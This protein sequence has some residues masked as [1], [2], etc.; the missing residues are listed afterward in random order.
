MKSILL[1]GGTG[2]IGT[3]FIN[4]FKDKF[5]IYILKRKSNKKSNIKKHKNIFLIYYKNINEIEY[6]I[7]RKKFDYLIN[8]A[9]HYTN[10]NDTNNLIKIVESNILFSTVVLNAINKNYLKKIISIGTMHEHSKNKY[11]APYNLYAAS[12]K[13]FYDMTKFYKLKYNQIKFYNLKFYET[14]SENDNRDKIIP[15]IIKNYKINKPIILSSPGL[16]LNFIHVK[17]VLSAINIILIKKIKSGDY[18]IKSS[19]FINIKNF[20]D[21]LN[22]DL[23]KKIKIK[24]NKK[25]SIKINY[26]FKKLPYWKQ[27]IKIEDF[28]KKF[29]YEKNKNKI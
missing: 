23:E 5:K 4:C 6:L 28:L 18:Q 25:K 16:N 14:F 11:F 29:F 12:K 22:K 13:A 24:T 2:F 20:I 9:T 19:N 1:T 27:T 7:C 15:K 3:N 8:L 26:D 21:K 17:D 10:Q